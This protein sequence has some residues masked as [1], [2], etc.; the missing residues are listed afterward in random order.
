MKAS[1]R[2][3]RRLLLQTR[4]SRRHILRAAVLAVFTTVAILAQATLLAYVIDRAALHGASLTAL[5]P[6]LGALAGVLIVRAALDGGFELSARLGA[7]GAMSELRGA[8]ARRLLAGEG[9]VRAAGRDGGELVAAAV[10]GVDALQDYFAGYLPQLLLATLVPVAVVAYAAVLDP[11]VAGLLALTVPILIVFMVLIGKAAGERTERRWRSLR[12][13]SSHFLDV[14]RGLATLRAHRRER[15][16]AEMLGRVGDRY[17]A[18][19]MAT[20]RLAFMSALVLELCAMLGTALAAATIGVQLASGALALSA[21]LTVLLLAP[22]LYGPLRRVGAAYHAAAGGA[23]AAGEIFALLDS[24]GAIAPARS[25]APV[26]AVPD[27][28][29]EPIR[30]EDVSYE[31]P[32]REDEAL[33]RLDLELPPCAITALL[34]PSG[35]GKSTVARLAMRLADPT[36]GVVSCGGVDLRRIDPEAWRAQVAWVAQRPQLYRG[37]IAE[38]IRLSRPDAGAEEVAAA[39]A[40]A[41]ATEFVEALPEGF[42]TI[43]GEGARRLSAGQR[44]RIA[45]ARAI[46][47]DARLLVLDEPTANLD[48]RH[49][50]RF[51]RMLPRLAAGRTVLLIVH[52]PAL[53]EHAEHAVA[54]ER[55]GIATARP[56][57]GAPA[58]AVAA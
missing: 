1:A 56:A 8:L 20:L 2:T 15:A 14:T 9:L 34:G 11:V 40:A 7:R 29:R 13:L 35:A 32:A 33:V 37:T 54:I 46:L 47:A 24:P 18:E 5:G 44:Q 31:Y 17:R 55:G 6:Q 50:R 39:A 53:A 16:Q 4:A 49:A 45:L 36:A 23:A 22:E 42:E 25:P 21:G 10:N 19:T 58:E 30:F 27:P 38:N 28:A 57:A 3:E 26:A 43:V 12:M 48:E 52:D 41:G 51:A